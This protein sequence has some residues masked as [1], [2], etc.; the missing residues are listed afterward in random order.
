MKKI[1]RQQEDFK[2]LLKLIEENPEL[3]IM[4]MV[5]SE[6]VSDDGRHMWWVGGWGA[7]SVEE[8]WSNDER[9]YIL[10]EDEEGLIGEVCD[11]ICDEP[12]YTLLTDDELEQ[13]AKEIIAG[14][15]WK[16]VIAVKINTP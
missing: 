4:A 14:Y 6:I 1:E 5:D 12:N 10:S 2:H 3:E 13:A 11:N 7:A 15:G 9:M 8:V 16:K